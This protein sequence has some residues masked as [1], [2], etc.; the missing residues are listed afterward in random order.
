MR[1]ATWI[2]LA[3]I[4]LSLAT[5]TIRTQYN[6]K[7]EKDKQIE[8]CIGIIKAKNLVI[9]HMKQDEE[10]YAIIFNRLSEKN[11]AKHQNR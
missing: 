9:K 10:D 8:V 5:E 6:E 11:K 3:I 4:F 1:N 2:V 7:R